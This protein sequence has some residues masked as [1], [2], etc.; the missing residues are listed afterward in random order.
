[1]NNHPTCGHTP[2]NSDSAQEKLRGNSTGELKLEIMDSI[3]TIPGTS[4]TILIVFQNTGNDVT[5]LQ[6]LNTTTLDEI[7]DPSMS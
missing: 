3:E 4:G 2:A 5:G 6:R 7:P 1:M